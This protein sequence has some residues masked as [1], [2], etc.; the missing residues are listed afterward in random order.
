MLPGIENIYFFFI[1]T[2]IKFIMNSALQAGPSEQALQ[3]QRGKYTMYHESLQANLFMGASAPL[4]Q[5]NCIM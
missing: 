4:P 1:L 3:F 2:Y 5:T